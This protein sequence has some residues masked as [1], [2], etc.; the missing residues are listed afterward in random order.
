M[1]FVH[2]RHT[3]D[4]KDAPRSPEARKIV[5]AEGLSGQGSGPDRVHRDGAE[6]EAAAHRRH[7][8]GRP[9][10]TRL[11]PESFGDLEFDEINLNTAIEI[12]EPFQ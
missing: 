2:S 3:D 8:P 10:L 5:V 11:L 12:I 7:H 6:R 9:T 4:D 1:R